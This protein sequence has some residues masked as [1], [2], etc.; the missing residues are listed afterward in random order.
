MGIRIIE[1]T[2]LIISFKRMGLDVFEPWSCFATKQFE[3]IS[4]NCNQAVLNEE[5]VASTG[6]A[7]S[8]CKDLRIL[9]Y[10]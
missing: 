8:K 5:K 3:I 7:L 6:T 9:A 1:T 4:K 2:L 10:W